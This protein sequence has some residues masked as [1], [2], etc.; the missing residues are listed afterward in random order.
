VA[1]VM[2]YLSTSAITRIFASAEA[3]EAKTLC[4]EV[5][6]SQ[7]E[8]NFFNLAR[9]ALETD[10]EEQKKYLQRAATSTAPY[11]E[12]I[13]GQAAFQ[14]SK[15]FYVSAPDKMMP[16]IHIEAWFVRALTLGDEEAAKHF[17]EF[18]LHQDSRKDHNAYTMQ[19]CQPLFTSF[20]AVILAGAKIKDFESSKLLTTKCE[21]SGILI[22]SPLR[23]A[24]AL[25][26]PLA[27]LQHPGSYVKTIADVVISCGSSEYF[28]NF[29]RYCYDSQIVA[30]EVYSEVLEYLANHDMVIKQEVLEQVASEQVRLTAP[31]VRQVQMVEEKQSP[32]VDLLGGGMLTS[33]PEVISLLPPYPVAPLLADVGGL[34]AQPAQPQRSQTAAQAKQPASEPVDPFAGLFKF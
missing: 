6:K 11:G 22:P 4:D 16:Y 17:C 25:R 7:P 1:L 2:R 8:N 29:F 3:T 19:N 23:L 24:H 18:G 12:N 21:T 14:L 20:L 31:V 13:S 33:K 9:A 10:R 30:K 32:V 27:V 28:Y 5:L 26:N 34:W 15:L